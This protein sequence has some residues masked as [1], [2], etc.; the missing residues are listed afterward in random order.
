MGLWERL[1]GGLW[2]RGSEWVVQGKTPRF[3]VSVSGR[4][5]VSFPEWGRWRL[6]AGRARGH[7]ELDVGLLSLR[8]LW[9]SEWSQYLDT[10]GYINLGHIGEA[11]AGSLQHGDDEWKGRSWG[12]NIWRKERSGLRMRQLSQTENN[13]N[14]FSLPAASEHTLWGPS[15]LPPMGEG[16][17]DHRLCPPC[18][19]WGYAPWGTA[20][21]GQGLSSFL[22]VDGGFKRK[23]IK[24]A[25]HTLAM[26]YQKEKLRKQPHIPLHKKN[27]MSRNKLT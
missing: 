21:S 27:K 4:T 26:K 6:W 11:W 20:N 13:S 5:E 2:G 9:S 22:C 18:S 24:S 17:R 16:L 14:V 8:Y 12:G 3:W 23:N 19:G 7:G 1:M 15:L 25:R 10:V